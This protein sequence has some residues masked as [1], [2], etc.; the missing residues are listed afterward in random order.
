MTKKLFEIKTPHH[1]IK[2]I[3]DYPIR[4]MVFGSGICQEQ[5]AINLQNPNEHVYDYSHLSLYVSFFIPKPTNIL[6]LG[7]GGA[8]IPNA[9]YNIFPEA[10]IDIVEIDPEVITLAEKYFNFKSGGRMKVYTGDAFTLLP[11]AKKYDVVVSDIFT[12]NYIPFHIMSSEFLGKIRNEVL[13]S[14]GVMA[15]NVCNEHPSFK[16]HLRT[17]FNSFGD[18]LYKIDGPTNKIMSMIFATCGLPEIDGVKKLVLN[19]E[20]LNSKIFSLKNS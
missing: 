9:F 19:D 17:I 4:K 14:K 6:I 10:D 11:W 8:V 16:S 20:V 1:H 15:V 5:S 12:T 3:E 2:I 18:H 7:L 13:K